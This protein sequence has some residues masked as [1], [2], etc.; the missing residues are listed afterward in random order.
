MKTKIVKDENSGTL[1]KKWLPT[2][3]CN[4]INRTLIQFKRKSPTKE[5]NP[6]KSKK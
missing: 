5:I 1:Q 6:L 4:K 3:P 2:Y